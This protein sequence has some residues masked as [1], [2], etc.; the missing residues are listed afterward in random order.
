MVF[1]NKAALGCLGTA[2]G[3]ATWVFWWALAHRWSTISPGALFSIPGVLQTLLYV[4]AFRIGSHHVVYHA[5]NGRKVTLVELVNFVRRIKGTRHQWV[6]LGV[7]I[8]EDA[9]VLSPFIIAA[10]VTRDPRIQLAIQGVLGLILLP[11]A[12]RL[13]L[14]LPLACVCPIGVSACLQRAI[15]LTRGHERL[16]FRLSMLLAAVWAGSVVLF[17]WPLAVLLEPTELKLAMQILGCVIGSV[18]AVVPAVLFYELLPTNRDP[19]TTRL[20]LA[21]HAASEFHGINV[22][23]LSRPRWGGSELELGVQIDNASKLAIDSLSSCSWLQV[24]ADGATRILNVSVEIV[25][26]RHGEIRIGLINRRFGDAFSWLFCPSVGTWIDDSVPQPARGQVGLSYLAAL[27]FVALTVTTL[28]GSARTQSRW[29]SCAEDVE[30]AERFR[31]SGLLTYSEVE[32]RRQSCRW[33]VV[34]G[35][36]LYGA[37]FLGAWFFLRRALGESTRAKN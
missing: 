32:A 16:I 11:V 7:A 13:P 22:T 28:S 26:E 24:S 31:E 17:V 23:E 35:S 12:L 2:L 36:V 21:E 10:L 14:A 18:F 9:I 8:A 34:R 25:N 15:A 27:A 29:R 3:L 20:E 19:R 37:T 4:E 30:T 5:R 1:R 33:I 6:V